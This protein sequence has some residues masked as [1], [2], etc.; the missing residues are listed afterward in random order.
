MVVYMSI[1][2]FF[3]QV[4]CPLISDKYITLAQLNPAFGRKIMLGILMVNLVV[5]L[6]LLK[7]F[8]HDSNTFDSFQVA[9]CFLTFSYGGILG[10]LPSFLTDMYGVYNSGTMHGIIF[11][12]WSVCAIGGGLTFQH[13]FLSITSAFPIEQ[14]KQG[15]LAAYD[16][17]VHWLLIVACV[18]CALI[19]FVHSFLATSTV[20]VDGPSFASQN[21]RL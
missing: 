15:M 6:A 16:F 11:T 8:I 1:S 18:G 7:H 19:P 3:G 17:N 10:T 20:F 12:A 2:N 14:L 13:Y 9:L 21:E 4:L 5:V